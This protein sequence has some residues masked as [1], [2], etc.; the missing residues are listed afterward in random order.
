MAGARLEIRERRE[1]Q[2]D[3][4]EARGMMRV[5]GVEVRTTGPAKSEL[6]R[7]RVVA[8]DGR[9][10]VIAVPHL[11]RDQAIGHESWDRVVQAHQAG[12]RQ[13]GHPASGPDDSRD[14]ADRRAEARNER[15]PAFRDEA[16]ERITAIGGVSSGDQRIGDVWAADRATAAGRH[17]SQQLIAI[18]RH[19][20][21]RQPRD[22]RLDA[23]TAIVP[24]RAKELD[25][26]RVIRIEEV[27][28]D[29]DVAG[30]LDRRDFD[31]GHETH[32]VPRR[33]IRR[34]RQTCGR[35]VIG[36]AENGKARG[37]GL[38]NELRRRERAV[39]GGRVKMEVDHTENDEPHPQVDFAFG[40]LIV[41][42]PPVTL[43]TKS[44]SAPRR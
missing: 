37:A 31:A 10:I 16:I 14:L 1:R 9:C 36:D 11:D 4:A 18:E 19:A 17:A 6:T 23:A 41:K 35:V 13:R 33:G 34:F 44:T 29:V 8:R 24:L 30:P 32:A 3:L 21:I 20:E 42:P 15:R 38:G 5:I 40:F 2:R 22:H 25:E 7:H 27:T 39:G 12:M 26:R 43:S 28:E